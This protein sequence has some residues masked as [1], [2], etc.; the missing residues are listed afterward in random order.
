[1]QC[2]LSLIRHITIEKDYSASSL[3]NAHLLLTYSSLHVES[4]TMQR[5]VSISTSIAFLR[6]YH[7]VPVSDKARASNPKK[8]RLRHRMMQAEGCNEF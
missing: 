6:S 1:M 4:R 3:K 7:E 2:R 5:R 8:P